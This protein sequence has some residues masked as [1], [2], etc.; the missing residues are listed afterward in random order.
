MVTTISFSEASVIE[1]RVVSRVSTRLT[2]SIVIGALQQRGFKRW[3]VADQLAVF[4]LAE[5]ASGVRVPAEW[6]RNLI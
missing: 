6:C 4:R 2:A 5:A 1:P 3:A